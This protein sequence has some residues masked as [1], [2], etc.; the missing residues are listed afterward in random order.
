MRIALVG[1]VH[2]N[3]PALEAVL[4]HAAERDARRVWNVGDFVGYGAFP[5]KVVS[6]L[7]AVGEVSVIGNYD[8][9]VLAFPENDAAWRQSKGSEKYVAFGW[10][11]R[12]LSADNR[13]YLAALPRERRINVDGLT[14]LLTHGSPASVHEHLYPDTPEE[15]LVELVAI[16]AVDAIVCGHS[17]RPFVRSMAATTF[18]NTGSVGRPDDGDPRATYAVLHVENGEFE[19]EHHRVAYD[20]D[21]AVAAIREHELPEAFAQMM[22]H[23]RKLGWVLENL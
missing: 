7:R 3:L 20:V 10:A 4:E 21:R 6:C 23:G 12:Q 1:D 11:W 16:A 18:I 9:K 15:R 14:V 5:D 8:Q 22:I 17:H 13:A 19:V 2:A